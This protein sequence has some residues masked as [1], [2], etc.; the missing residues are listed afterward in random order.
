MGRWIQLV[1]M[2]LWQ[3]QPPNLISEDTSSWIVVKFMQWQLI[4]THREIMGEDYYCGKC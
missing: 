3:L 1:V 2:R 4:L